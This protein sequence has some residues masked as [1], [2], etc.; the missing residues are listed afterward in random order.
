MSPRRAA[1][2]A[3]QAGEEPTTRAGQRQED[4]REFG[5]GGNSERYKMKEKLVTFGDD[6][7]IENE[8]G[9]KAF[10]VDGRMVAVRDVLAFEDDQGHVLVEMDGKIVDVRQK[11]KLKRK[12]GKSA[13]VRKD[14]VNIVRDQFVIDVDGGDE[15]IA[16]GNILDHEYSISRGKDQVAEISK[17][18]FRVRDTY[19]VQVESGQDAI[20][21][22]AAT[23]A[24]DQLSHDTV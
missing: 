3:A 13:V 1:N 17:R 15:L 8:E 9:R 6:F 20:M 18:W 11:I 24:I 5:V 12:G 16:S 4:R 14:L 22:L 21:L 19:G 2:G 23:V 10:K 7:W